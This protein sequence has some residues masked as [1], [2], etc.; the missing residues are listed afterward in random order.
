M[1]KN[2]I[3][4]GISLTV[5]CILF[6]QQYIGV[7]F[8]L[9]A[10]LMVACLI[11]KDKDVLKNKLWL[12]LAVGAV[13][14]GI[15]TTLYGQL[16]SAIVSAVS[17]VLLAS[18]SSLKDSSLIFSLLHSAYSYICL[19]Y[20][21]YEDYDATIKGNSP[22]K[23]YNYKNWLIVILPLLVVI[24]FFSLYKSANPLFDELTKKINLDF[25]SWPFL[26]FTFL[27]WLLIYIYYNQRLIIQLFQKDK[28][29]EED[30][31]EN[32][33][34]KE[35][36][37]FKSLSSE[38][39]S[40]IIMFIMLNLLL[41]IVNILDMKFLFV[42]RVL[43]IGVSHSD[44]V[45]QG[46]STLITSIII[47][48]FIT[49]YYFRGSLNF[50]EKNSVLKWL[51]YLWLLQNMVLVITSG[52]KNQFYVEDYGLTYK[53]IGVYIYLLLT[54]IGLVTT[55]VK[56]TYTKSNWFLLRKNTWLFY[57]VFI[58]SGLIHWDLLIIDYNT[59]K[60]KHKEFIYLYQLSDNCLPILLTQK[61]QIKSK[62]TNSIDDEYLLK[63]LEGRKINFLLLQ[64]HKQWPSWNLNNQNIYLQ[65]KNI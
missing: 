21:L 63:N 44:F 1:K 20:Y 32:S 64:K 52:N 56:I 28:M 34:R 23:N 30:L 15:G 7:N 61:Q 16:L 19:P 47:A 18:I 27:G 45:H 6:Y 62:R 31:S 8:L 46:V 17:L 51:A 9:F 42:N 11:I 38:Y 10:L 13:I 3:L 4:I 49:L 40:A 33:N 24:I 59:N 12:V 2:K 54:L 43:P 25:I 60:A 57:F 65:L 55:M 58:M 35:F 36:S 37:L 53:R 39:Q 50:L 22:K 48:I 26:R 29:I 41:L 5:Y 14:G